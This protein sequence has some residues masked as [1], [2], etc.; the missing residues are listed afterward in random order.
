[1]PSTNNTQT[2]LA[3][4]NL[5]DISAFGPSVIET[6]RPS[7][8]GSNSPS[9]LHN[10]AILGYELPETPQNF[11]DPDFARLGSLFP[12]NLHSAIQ[13]HDNKADVSITFPPRD[14]CILRL[15]ILPNKIQNLAM[16]LFGLNVEIDGSLRYVRSTKGR[17]S[18]PQPALREQGIETH[19]ISGLFGFVIQQ[20]I[21]S[22]SIRRKE[23]R[24][25]FLSLT[26]C[27][28][29]ELSKNSA[30]CAYLYI[31][32]GTDVGI[33]VHSQLFG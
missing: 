4:S 16:E 25:G 27:G 17:K 11:S 10:Q 19:V 13:Q 3:E 6:P 1:M 5:H 30:E 23:T 31:T 20:G 12:I 15:A 33:T 22:S 29:M 14:D 18:I 28:E 21:E 9:F 7:E 32:I 24:N 2:T 8:S 26:A